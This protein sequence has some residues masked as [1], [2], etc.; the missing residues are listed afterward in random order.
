MAALKDQTTKLGAPNIDGN[1]AV[2]GRDAPALYFGS[3]KMNNNF[4]VVDAVAEEGGQGMAASLFVKSGNDYIRVATN[5]STRIGSGRG[6]GRVLTGPAL[7][8]IKAGNAYYGKA[9][10]LGTPYISGYEPIKDASGAIHRRL[11][12]R[13]QEVTT[14]SNCLGIIE[15][16]GDD[17]ESHCGKEG[18]SKPEIFS[19][20]SRSTPYILNATR[21]R[22][23]ASACRDGRRS[24]R[25]MGEKVKPKEEPMR[26]TLIS[27]AVVGALAM[28]FVPTSLR[29]STLPGTATITTKATI[30]L[31]ATTAAII[32][33]SATIITIIAI[34]DRLAASAN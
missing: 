4:S 14:E 3:T 19:E 33:T 18:K 22:N 16:H 8:L 28:T 31:T 26:Q 29:H 1:D 27:F 32:I 11:F 21:M 12:R 20:P 17:D 6:I 24:P 25:V 10:V 34:G 5:V 13:L 23:A 9:P 15:I 7:E 30:T 2:G